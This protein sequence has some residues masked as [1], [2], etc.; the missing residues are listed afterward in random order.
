[1]DNEVL[2]EGN[3]CKS[4]SGQE[5]ENGN[6]IFE[7]EVLFWAFYFQV[8]YLKIQEKLIYTNLSLLNQKML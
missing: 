8:F 4:V 6:Y 3:I 5:D 7:V 1:M 2:I